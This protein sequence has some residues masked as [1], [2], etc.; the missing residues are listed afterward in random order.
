MLL[1]NNNR[2]PENVDTIYQLGIVYVMKND[3]NN[4]KKCIWY[5]WLIYFPET[6]LLEAI[7]QS[8]FVKNHSKAQMLFN[9][10]LKHKKLKPPF[11]IVAKDRFLSE[12]LLLLGNS[13]P[14]FN[15]STNEGAFN[16]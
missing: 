4:M 12:I 14:I 13:L 8:L 1:E 9:A 16:L 6:L 7:N 11:E 5:H 10:A 3:Q 2:F 15:K